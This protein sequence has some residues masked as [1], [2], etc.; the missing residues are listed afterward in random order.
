MTKEQIALS[1]GVSRMAIWKVE[2]RYKKCGEDGLK[3]HKPGRLFESLS[4]KFYNLVV[5]EWKKNKYA[6]PKGNTR[7]H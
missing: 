2:Q 3:T 1:M 4:E 7:G 6:C 5:E